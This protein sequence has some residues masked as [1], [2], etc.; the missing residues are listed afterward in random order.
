MLNFITNSELL[1]EIQNL[2]GY[3]KA[4]MEF[5]I[6]TTFINLIV[7]PLNIILLIYIIRKVNKISKKINQS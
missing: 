6:I 7:I 4:F 5:E 1:E 3:Y 2:Q